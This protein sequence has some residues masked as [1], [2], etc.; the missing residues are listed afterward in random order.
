MIKFDPIDT[1]HRAHL[2]ANLRKRF[3]YDWVQQFAKN[4]STP[5]LI[6]DVEEVRSRYQELQ[7]AFPLIRHHFAIKPLPLAPVVE[8]INR[9]H[10]HIDVASRGEI[11][12]AKEQGVASR[13]MIHTN[14]HRKIGDI[15]HAIQH[16]V[17]QFVVDNPKELNKFLPY[18]NHVK[19]ILRLSYP[20]DLSQVNLS[21]KFG[22]PPSQGLDLLET[23]LKYKF[24]VTGVSMHVGSQSDH[25][26]LFVQALEKTAQYFTDAKEQLGHEFQIL[27]IGGGFPA[28]YNKPVK[29]I[30]EFADK[31]NPLL[32]KYFSKMKIYSEPG[33]YVVNSSL[34]L[35]STIVGASR[36]AESDWYFI[37]DGLYGSF[38]G[39]LFD[40]S[41]YVMFGA[42]ELASDQDLSK[43]IIGGATCDSHDIVHDKMLLPKLNYGDITITPNIGA[44]S[45]THSTN[46][47]LIPRPKVYDRQGNLLG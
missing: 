22:V 32:E 10:G 28:E 44:Y 19:L 16:Q 45:W 2:L 46:F 1:E 5:C 37:D 20:N 43:F 47:N 31:I 36:R 40:F 17:E 11:E 23:M 41:G 34:T 9:Q 21:Y 7:T 25:T 26:E 33:R 4:Q 39:I 24:D 35:L 8:M 3:D 27:D 30:N 6:F 15:E 42:N 18:R 29:S 14:P 13:R 12:L 38:S